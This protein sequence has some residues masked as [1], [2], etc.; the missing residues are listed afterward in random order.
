MTQR[1]LHIL[2]DA[3]DMTHRYWRYDSWVLMIC[4]MDTDGMTLRNFI[5]S[6]VLH[7]V[8]TG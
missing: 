1:L 2:I 3:E 8:Y 7:I 5:P 4:F 6:Q